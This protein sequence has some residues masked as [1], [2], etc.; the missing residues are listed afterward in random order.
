[1]LSKRQVCRG[2][3]WIRGRTFVYEKIKIAVAICRGGLRRH[4]IRVLPGDILPRKT[5]ALPAQEH[6]SRCYLQSGRGLRGTLSTFDGD[7]PHPSTLHGWVGGLG[8][9]ARERAPDPP[10]PPFAVVRQEI[11]QRV[12][13]V[14]SRVFDQPVE[15]SPDR[16]LVKEDDP[17][18]REIRRDDLEFATKLLRAA[19]A[20]LPQAD[21]PLT[22]MVRLFLVSALVAPP[23]FW[24][25]I[26][27]TPIRHRAPGAPRLPSGRQE[28]PP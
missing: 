11:D 28:K 24:A 6:A 1:M 17:E 9:F 27:A 14:F 26:R 7:V 18:S 13:F 25:R 3:V 15:I 10:G 12:S 16:C 2:S 20:A 23:C 5:Y 21:F 22:E 19:R 8:R 4:E